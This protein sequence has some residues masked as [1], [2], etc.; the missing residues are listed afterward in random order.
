MPAAWL[1][2]AA[3]CAALTWEW[4]RASF[5]VKRE[6]LTTRRI[7]VALAVGAVGSLVLRFLLIL[8]PL[9]WGLV[10]LGGA[11]IAWAA[12]S[13]RRTTS[14][15][16]GRAKLLLRILRGAVLLLILLVA[17]GP[18]WNDQFDEPVREGLAVLVDT[19][20]SMSNEDVSLPPRAQS[21]AAT[22]AAEPAGGAM[23]RIE[24]AESAL[25]GQRGT[26]LRLADRY[27]FHTAGFDSHLR[28][29]AV[30]DM[31]AKGDR[32]AIGDAIQRA[33]DDFLAAGVPVAGIC[34]ITD[35][36]NNTADVV[37]PMPEAEAMASRGCALW[38]VG[39]GSDTSAQR[40]SLNIRNLTAPDKVDVMQEMAIA[41]DI[42]GVGLEGHTVT[43]QCRL[44]EQ[45]IGAKE[46]TFDQPVQTRRLMFTAAATAAGFHRLTVQAQRPAIGDRPLVGEMEFSRMVHV[47]SRT[48]RVLYIE[49]R[50]R[51]EGKFVAAALAGQERFSVTRMILGQPLPGEPDEQAARDFWQGYHVIIL[52]D[53]P[54]ASLGWGRL[55]QLSR[56]ISEEGRGLVMIAAGGW[57]DS[58]LA[59]ALPVV[60]PRQAPPLTGPIHILPTP[61]GLAE[62]V[63]RIGRDAN[64]SN[65][66]QRLRPLYEVDDL[67]DPKPAATVFARSAEGAAAK[68]LIVGQQYGA[69]RTIAIAFDTTWQW[70]LSPQDTADL[71]KRFWR[72]VLLWAG[73]PSTDAW[74]TTDS[75]RYDATRLAGGQERITVL[76]G[77]EDADGTPRMDLPVT[78]TL[79][80]PEGKPVVVALEPAGDVRK[81]V[82]GALP[83]GQYTLELSGQA[84]GRKLAA[85][86]VF[87]V[88]Q[89]DLE[90]T[91]VVAN[92]PLL[93]QMGELALAGGGG[94]RPLAELPQVLEQF[95]NR[96]AAVRQRTISDDLVDHSRRWL[97]AALIGMLVVEWTVRKA[98]GLV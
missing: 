34:V 53:C 74:V 5:L 26:C 14:P 77:A 71:Q 4:V 84:G 24:A 17:M 75:P 16:S 37:S 52:G 56:L 70:A 46:V 45:F 48:L 40:A 50:R 83:A 72:Q 7:A 94:Y 79:T 30:E 31:A 59:A 15:I 54:A 18:V 65:T 49:G 11:A 19:S 78:I 13:Y 96:P 64:D 41:A 63:M 36:C 61:E 1:V 90:T 62:G 8:S 58:Q 32:T 27:V 33:R 66:W 23:S 10:I 12:R 42:E 81:A 88:I 60:V 92:L 38:L 95:A 51:Y 55:E 89:R 67:G 80:D 43:V 21:A 2:I 57:A 47:T 98:L 93:R 29:Q 28:Y 97:L 44:G 9:V 69:G 25:A 35:G 82:L 73:N 20:S 76:A 86:H 91:E 87:E 39:V 22:G 6:R 85:K 3:A 68:P